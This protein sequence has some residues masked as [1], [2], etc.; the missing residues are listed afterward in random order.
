VGTA[1]VSICAAKIIDPI[2]ANVNNNWRPQFTKFGDG[3]YGTITQGAIGLA[4][5]GTFYCRTDV[6]NPDYIHASIRQQIPMCPNTTYYIS[7]TYAYQYTNSKNGGTDNGAVPGARNNDYMNV[8]IDGQ[9]V[10]SLNGGVTNVPALSGGE[11]KKV[12]MGKFNATKNSHLLELFWTCVNDK[13]SYRSGFLWLGTSY[14]VKENRLFVE[15]IY[16]SNIPPGQ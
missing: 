1:T 7:I 15:S 6:K 10:I 16:F 3:G 12:A 14:E 11:G 13:K 4:S 2:L 8:F 9:Y 5:G